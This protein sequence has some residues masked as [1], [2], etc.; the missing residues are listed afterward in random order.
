MTRGWRLVAAGLAVA[1]LGGCASVPTSG[2]I[3]QGPPLVADD[4]ELIYRAIP[5]PPLPGMTPDEVVRGFLAASSSGSDAYGVARSFLTPKAAEG[6]NPLASVR[7]YDNSGIQTKLATNAVSVSGILD[8]TI[9][10]DGGYTVAGAGERLDVSYRLAKVGTEWRIDQLPPGLVLGRGDVDRE[11]RTFNLYFFDPAFSVLV[12]D[13][14]TVP[15]VGSGLPTT[16]V[17]A[18][19]HGPTGWLAPAVR[20]AFPEGTALALDSVPVDQGI[21]QV[22]LSSQVLGASD[23]TRV[24]LS[25]QL[26]WT[27]GRL[28]NVTG[29]R[30]TVNGQPLTVLGSGPVQETDMWQAYDADSDARSGPAAPVLAAGRTG[31]LRV[32][33]DGT[34]VPA[35]G[36]FGQ[37]HPLVVSPAAVHRRHPGR[38]GQRRRPARALA[39][40]GEPGPRGRVGS[41]PGRPTCRG[42]AGT[43]PARCGSSTGVGGGCSSSSTTSRCPSRSWT[44]RRA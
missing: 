32:G 22:E 23:R 40:V 10:A 30:I 7:V 13:P 38:G 2:P 4:Q 5:Q 19:L 42:R 6:W 25:A 21:A 14:I 3:R 12:P 44:R 18:L 34:L 17:R 29:V 43:V 36:P 39:A 20:T 31:L 15:V 27:L 37:G 28:P 26:V 35:A 1:L 41:S 33:D 16:L 9:G 8:G 11:F 24:A